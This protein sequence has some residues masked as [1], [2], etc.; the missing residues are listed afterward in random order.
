MKKKVLT[1]GELR[2][3]GFILKMLEGISLIAIILLACIIVYIY[4]HGEK[5]PLPPKSETLQ[6]KTVNITITISNPADTFSPNASSDPPGTIK[7]FGKAENLTCTNPHNS[8][9]LV[10]RSSQVVGGMLNFTYTLPL[11]KET[12]IGFKL[13]GVI[14]ADGIKANNTPLTSFKVEGTPPA[15]WAVAC[16]IPWEDSEGRVH[17]LPSPNCPAQGVSPNQLRFP[18]DAFQRVH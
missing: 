15:I 2:A 4:P 13:N 14:R 17:I 10:D 6:E 16:F 12:D 9:C 18:P 1:I 8:A 5:K 3:R 7:T 11:N